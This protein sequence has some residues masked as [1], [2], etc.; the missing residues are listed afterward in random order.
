V[1]QLEE[2]LNEYS[3]FVSKGILD[4]EKFNQYSVT[5]HS[6]AIEGST[7]TLVETQLLLEDDLTCNKPFLHHL[8][9]KD[10][11]E[12]LLF[13]IDNAKNKVDLTSDFI[14]QINAR[15]M[16]N[17]GG[18]VN[19]ILGSY[20]VS[21]GEFRKSSVVAGNHIFVDSKK[22]EPLLKEVV[23]ETNAKMKSNLSIKEKFELSFDAHFNIVSIHPF[24]DGN[25][26]TSRLVMN[27]LQKYFNL[28]LVI[29]YEDDKSKYIEAL[30][31]TRKKED[32]TVFRNFMFSQLTRFLKEEI[33]KF[34]SENKSIKKRNGL[35]FIF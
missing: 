16:K 35:S 8:M 4:Y 19:S 1:K 18:I 30:N 5:H 29:V 33:E 11:Y 24:G 13:V 6:S 26:R 14:Q 31:E 28:P 27:Y 17:T 23:L 3:S 21:K 15:V 32:I 10:H 7:L 22:V 9:V 2:Q 20:D 12:A 34:K 25:G